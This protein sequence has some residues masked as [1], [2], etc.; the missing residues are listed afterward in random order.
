MSKGAREMESDAAELRALLERGASHSLIDVREYPEYAACRIAEARLVPLGEI[1]RRAGEI[2]TGGPL[3]LICRSGRR[4]AIAQ[5]KLLALG[6]KEVYNVRGG[7]LD[8]QSRGFAVVSDERAPWSLERQVRFVA[9]LLVFVSVVLSLT[10]AQPFAWLAAFIGAG[11]TFA[12]ITDTCAMGM[13]IA[14][15]PWNRAPE[16]GARACPPERGLAEE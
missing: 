16:A 12:A 7:M 3:Y 5:Q 1:E 2:N 15:L 13:L 6:F 11:L 14:R 8:W 10:V 9:G 4:S